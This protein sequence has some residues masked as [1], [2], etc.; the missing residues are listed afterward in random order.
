M[1][2]FVTFNLNCACVTREGVSD[3]LFFG[4]FV[5]NMY[6]CAAKTPNIT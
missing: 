1:S 4:Q 5:E 6:L 3:K 2:L